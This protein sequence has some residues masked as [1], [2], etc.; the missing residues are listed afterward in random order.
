MSAEAEHCQG[1]EGVGGLESVPD[2]GDQPDFGV[3]RFDPAVGQA[4]LDG[5]QDAVSV[6]ATHASLVC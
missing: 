3:D 2:P 1:D 4:V 5:S 6:L